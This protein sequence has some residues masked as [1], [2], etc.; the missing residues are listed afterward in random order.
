[1]SGAALEELSGR[2]TAEL[3][4]IVGRE[5]KNDVSNAAFSPWSLVSFHSEGVTLLSTNDTK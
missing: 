3:G 5:A 2:V 4:V 1:M